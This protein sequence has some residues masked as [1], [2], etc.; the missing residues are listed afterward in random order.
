MRRAA[1]ALVGRALGPEP[2]RRRACSARAS[3][4]S[5]WSG[6]SS[7]G[8]LRGGAQ[9]AGVDGVVGTGGGEGRVGQ[10]QPHLVGGGPGTEAHVGAVEHQGH[11]RARGQVGH[12]L[13]LLVADGRRQLL[14]DVGEQPHARARDR[15]SRKLRC[16]YGLSS[17]ERSPSRPIVNRAS[18]STV[19]H[20]P[21]YST[22][23]AG[24][25]AS[26]PRRWPARR[27]PPRIVS[28]VRHSRSSVSTVSSSSL[29]VSAGPVVG[30]LGE[31]DLV[32]VALLLRRHL[33]GDDLGRRRPRS[34]AMRTLLGARRR[35][36]L[37]ERAGVGC[38][39]AGLTS[40]PSFPA[41]EKTKA[42]ASDHHQRGCG[43]G[44]SAS[45]G[46]RPSAPRPRPA[47]GA[48]VAAGGGASAVWSPSAASGS[49]V[50]CASSQRGRSPREAVRRSA[51][52]GGTIGDRHRA[53]DPL[54]STRCSDVRRV[55][56]SSV[57]RSGAAARRRCRRSAA[58]SGPARARPRPLAAPGRRPRRSRS[59]R[60]DPAPGRSPAPARAT[61]G[62][63]AAG[64][65]QRCVEHPLDEL[66]LR[67][68][69]P[70][71]ERRPAGEEGVDRGAERVDVGPAVAGVA[72]LSTSGAAKGT[73][74]PWLT[75]G[76]RRR[77]RRRSRSR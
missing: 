57:V 34:G 6:V 26:T 20:S 16:R 49:D 11:H 8:D 51:A 58:A 74:T 68:A 14:A 62:R 72:P 46:P 71:A 4:R 43:Q 37:D 42:T 52:A 47:S 61:P 45:G 5:R 19:N 15:S 7:A 32:G 22:R 13:A 40:S 33:P 55:L 70:G 56:S 17:T 69:L 29:V 1:S 21:Q 24:L 63:R 41:L 31:E 65:R 39:G 75:A 3:T 30:A 76:P 36:G 18:A 9:P 53:A 12:E 44:G 67:Q 27:A 73:D 10:H 50:G 66:G 35:A 60:P 54:G 64:G 48:A 2:V 23:R 38:R 59:G 28:T 77:R 25:T